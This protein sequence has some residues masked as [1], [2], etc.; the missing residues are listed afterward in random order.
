MNQQLL[1]SLLFFTSSV[2]WAV[3]AYLYEDYR[4][5]NIGLFILFL[6]MGIVKRKKYL[7]GRDEP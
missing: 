5:L 4:W 3:L 2:I 7:Q 1:S 6:V